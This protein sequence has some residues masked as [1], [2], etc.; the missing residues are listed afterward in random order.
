MIF[1]QGRQ[2]H[3]IIIEIKN[4]KLSPAVARLTVKVEAEVTA[5]ICSSI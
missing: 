5:L 1:P 4:N 3:E 2:M